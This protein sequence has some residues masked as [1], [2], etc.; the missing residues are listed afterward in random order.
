M[1]EKK[2][3]AKSELNEKLDLILQN[4]QR[5]LDNEE[6]ILGE[7]LKL[8]EME[9]QDLEGDQK[10]IH[11]EEQALK[12]LEKLE[13]NLKSSISSPLKKITTQDFVK[14]FIGAFIGVMGHFAFAKAAD[15]ALYL[16][17]IRATLMYI[18]ALIIIIGMLYFTGFRKIEKHIV[19]KFIPLRATSL[20]FV[21]I[22]TILFVNLLFNKI[23][24]PLSFTEV[25]NLIAANIILASMGAATADLIGRVEG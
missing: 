12:E 18:V 23:Y 13:K 21:S 1:G 3:S 19:M 5:I 16:D 24:F 17:P 22:I 14:G 9:R 15:I 20:F 25:Y 4:Q 8:E 11:S 7:E 6:K 10:T 2:S